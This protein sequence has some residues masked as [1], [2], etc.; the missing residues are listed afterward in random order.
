MIPV[1][2]TWVNT[3][4]HGEW[5]KYFDVQPFS[6]PTVVFYNPATHKHENTIG[7]FNKAEVGEYEHRFVRGKLSTR[8]TQTPQEDLQFTIKDCAAPAFK[9]NE[10]DDD[11][12]EILAEILAEEEEKK[13]G[14]ESDLRYPKKDKKKNKKKK[15]KKSKKDEL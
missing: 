10:G 12:D 1:Y 7:K 13:A 5:F 4:C 15:K 6:A 9:A 8:A 11:F 2:Y 3:T 14:E